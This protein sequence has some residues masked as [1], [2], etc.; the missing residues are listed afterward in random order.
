MVRG[1]FGATLLLL[2]LC[3]AP[4]AGEKDATPTSTATPTVTSAPAP[5]ATATPK[6]PGVVSGTVYHDRDLDGVRDEGEEGLPGWGVEV[7]PLISENDATYPDAG[8]GTTG[9]D[10]SFRAEDL[11]VS[12]QTWAL[13]VWPPYDSTIEEY[14]K[15]MP[16]SPKMFSFDEAVVEIDVPIVFDEDTSATFH[17][18]EDF[19]GDGAI[20]A[21]DELALWT[22]VRIETPDGAWVFETSGPKTWMTVTGLLPGDYVAKAAVDPLNTVAFTVDKGGNPEQPIELLSKAQVTF[23]GYVYQDINENAVRDS[24]EPGLASA[25]IEVETRNPDGSGSGGGGK[26]EP[27]GSYVLA[28]MTWPAGTGVYVGCGNEFDAVEPRIDLEPG[29]SWQGTTGT[30]YGH[31]G[32]WFQDAPVIIE[33]G[34]YRYA[35]DCGLAYK[36]PQPPVFVPVP[37]S[38]DGI[39]LPDSGSASDGRPFSEWPALTLVG[40]AAVLVGLAMR[41]RSKRPGPHRTRPRYR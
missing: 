34:V 4:V 16:P 26:T 22:D 17:V 3:A 27:D 31:H 23:Y 36:P 6:Y 41:C 21:D 7:H 28:Y 37:I 24:G 8:G 25:W 15:I 1:M 32:F 11:D 40:A 2:A 12:W 10:G 9:S 29:G 30:T 14:Y 13:E 38:G 5:T 33:A 39:A 18:W 20:S 19:D 35:V